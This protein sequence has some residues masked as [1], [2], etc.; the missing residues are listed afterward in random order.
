MPP[1]TLH[2]STASDLMTP[3]PVSLVD[4]ATVAEAAAFLA[5]HEFGAAVVIDPAGHRVG[6]VTKTDLL[7]H[8]RVHGTNPAD[9]TPVTAVMTPAV[10]TIRVEAPAASVVE[11]L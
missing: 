2:A 10:Y 3:A 5:E 11:Q 9:T 4:S 7:H 8:A 1:L 6:V